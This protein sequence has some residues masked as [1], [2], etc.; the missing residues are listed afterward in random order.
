MSAPTLVVLVIVASLVGITT[1]VIVGT[2]AR[3]RDEIDHLFRAFSRTEPTLVPV[4]VAVDSERDRLR[5]R[6]AR[7]SDPGSGTDA[8]HR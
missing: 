8:D 2:S 7:L 4:R 5:E 1:V 3:L 6:L